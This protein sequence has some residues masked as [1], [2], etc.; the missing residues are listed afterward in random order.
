[1]FGLSLLGFGIA[2]YLGLYQLEVIPRV[3]EPFF[4]HGSEV[5]LRQSS[6][7]HL[8]PIPDALLG[9]FAYFSEAVLEVIGGPL[10]WRTMPGIVL[11]LG[12]LGIGLGL[13][14]IALVICQPTLFHA[15][16]TL[17]LGSAVCSVL[18]ALLV[19]PEVWA[20]IGHVRQKSAEGQP[21]WQAL[22]N[23]D[24]HQVLAR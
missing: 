2:L 21:M 15:W 11:L 23:G 9:A 4:G 3:W 16:C 5:I 18:I 24:L 8:L 14:G 19:M 22:W 12:L 1:V 10:R 20:S 13:T 7:A 6:L 17:C